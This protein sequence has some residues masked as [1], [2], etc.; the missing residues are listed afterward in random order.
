[1]IVDVQ[2]WQRLVDA[3]EGSVTGTWA[4]TW[5]FHTQLVFTGGKRI[6]SA[7]YRHPDTQVDSSV[8]A[9]G[10]FKGVLERFAAM[11]G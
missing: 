1:M 9:P 6:G 10:V 11:K 8:L 5:V 4:G 3:E 2:E 7:V